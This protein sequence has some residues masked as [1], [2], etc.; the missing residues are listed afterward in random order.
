MTNE[1]IL[2]DLKREFK[3]STIWVFFCSILIIIVIL[4]VGSRIE[5]KI[6]NLDNKL[7]SVI[8]RIK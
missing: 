5:D 3:G 8:V 2:C 6:K 1:E 4:M 7:D